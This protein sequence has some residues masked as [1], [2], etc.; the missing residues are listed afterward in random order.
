MDA[1]LLVKNSH[2]VGCYM[3]RPCAHLYYWKLLRKV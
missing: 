1:T 2:I 3:L